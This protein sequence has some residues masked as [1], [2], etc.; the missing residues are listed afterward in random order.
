M[1]KLYRLASV[2]TILTLLGLPDITAGIC[3]VH[4][5]LVFILMDGMLFAELDGTLCAETNRGVSHYRFLPVS[6]DID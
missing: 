6:R 5:P 3:D 1:L 2:R 4:V